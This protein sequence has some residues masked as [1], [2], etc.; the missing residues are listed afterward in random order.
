MN[1]RESWRK[2]GV[3][4]KR[5]IRA[6]AALVAWARVTTASL[7]TLSPRG[8]NTP[9]SKCGSFPG[10]PYS[11]VSRKLWRGVGS[12]HAG[13]TFES[14]VTQVRR[15]SIAAFVKTCG[16]FPGSES[17]SYR[18]RIGGRIV[19]IVSGIVLRHDPPGDR[20]PRS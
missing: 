5:S 13:Q 6:E 18:D 1:P 2:L 7:S 19:G 20:S 12:A 3:T 11:C 9:F 10:G 16:E 14:T 17:S 4:R 8:L 15:G